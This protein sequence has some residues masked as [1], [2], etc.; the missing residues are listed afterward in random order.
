M[1]EI[2]PDL[3]FYNK[4]DCQLANCNYFDEPGFDDLTKKIGA[5][6]KCFSLCHVNIRSIKKNLPNFITYMDCLDFNFPIIGL[7]ETWLKDDNCDVYNIEQ[8]DLFEKHRT[9]KSG[10]GVGLFIHQDIDFTKRLDLCYFD[11]YIE[12]ISIELHKH[13]FDTNR[14][15]II[16][17]IYRPPKTDT[18]CFNDRMQILLDIINNE[19]SF[20]T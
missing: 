14:N 2:D 1:G 5:T 18:R 17:V 8:Y 3:N 12:C 7:S 19:K 10:G 4:I 15:I 20:V 11:D 6:N 16:S 9:S 13:V